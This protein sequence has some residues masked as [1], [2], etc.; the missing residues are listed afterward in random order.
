MNDIYNKHNLCKISEINSIMLM[1]NL[2]TS[3]SR[4]ERQFPH[5]RICSDQCYKSLI[6]LLIGSS[7]FAY[8]THCS[9]SLFISVFFIYASIIL[10]KY[11][12]MFYC[13]KIINWLNFE[14]LFLTIKACILYFN[15]ISL[16]RKRKM[17]SKYKLLT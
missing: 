6:T 7:T 15:N 5:F 2:N 10:I 1:S 16:N 4:C 13:I 11:L 17:R 9:V 12:H 14:I 3:K 8:D